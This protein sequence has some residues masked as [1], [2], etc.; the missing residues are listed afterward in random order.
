V[1]GEKQHTEQ[2]AQEWESAWSRDLKL[3]HS[4]KKHLNIGNNIHNIYI[5]AEWGSRREEM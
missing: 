2:E 4:Y 1:K 3:G 5:P